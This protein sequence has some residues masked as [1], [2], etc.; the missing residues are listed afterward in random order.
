MT[1]SLTI[2]LLLIEHATQFD[3]LD[4]S[5]YTDTL[6]S[7]NSFLFSFAVF[8]NMITDD[9]DAERHF[10]FQKRNFKILGYIEFTNFTTNINS[11]ISSYQKKNINSKYIKF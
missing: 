7:R 6:W 2:Q 1:A 9:G 5:L 3:I 11:T 4:I 8:I 10:A